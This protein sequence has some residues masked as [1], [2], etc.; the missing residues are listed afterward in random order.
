MAH[1]GCERGPMHRDALP[2]IAQ[3]KGCFWEPQSL[4]EK[5]HLSFFA[6][7]GVWGAHQHDLGMVSVQGVFLGVFHTL[8][9]GLKV[10][11]GGSGV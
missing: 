10:F 6:D 7:I 9:Q 3:K 2:Y 1:K 8:K 4:Q 11:V 5:T